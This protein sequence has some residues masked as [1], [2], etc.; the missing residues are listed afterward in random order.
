MRVQDGLFWL[1]KVHYETMVLS[2]YFCLFVWL[3]ICGLKSPF[4][5]TYDTVNYKTIILTGATVG[6]SLYIHYVDDYKY[7]VYH[8]IEIILICI[9]SIK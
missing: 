9:F 5:Y 2:N 3:F 4:L 6:N 7:N 1:E 8:D